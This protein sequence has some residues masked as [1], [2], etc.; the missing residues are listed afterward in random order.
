MKKTKYVLADKKM[1]VFLGTY[2]SEEW[3]DDSDEGKIYIC[4]ASQN[5]FGL[6][7]ACSFKTKEHAR[8]FVSNAF[9]PN[10]RKDL[11]ILPVESETEYPSAIELIKSGHGDFTHDMIDGLFDDKS[12]QTRK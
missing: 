11:L 9:P 4:F 7:S 2:N 5:P 3:G 12:P 8:F 6:T 1:G 10:K